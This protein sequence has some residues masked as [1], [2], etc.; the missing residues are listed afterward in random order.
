MGDS[1]V[2]NS[3][4]ERWQMARLVFWFLFILPLWV[5]RS[6]GVHSPNH[7]TILMWR[8][9]CALVGL[10]GWSIC[11]LVMYFRFP[12]P[13]KGATAPNTGPARL[14]M[15]LPGNAPVAP[16]P[17]GVQANPWDST[18]R[19]AYAAPATPQP[20]PDLSGP[21]WI[22]AYQSQRA[23]LLRA[24]LWAMSH[25]KPDRGTLFVLLG[26]PAF[27]V[28][29][30]LS[31]WLPWGWLGGLVASVFCLL[32]CWGLV[33]LIIWENIHKRF[34]RADTVRGGHAALTSDGFYDIMDTKTAFAPWSDVTSIRQHNG[35]FFIRYHNPARTAVGGNLITGAGFPD[36]ATADQFYQSALTLWKS[37]GRDLPDNFPHSS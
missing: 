18:I 6:V 30:S 31:M 36:R 2:V 14:A 37:G 12:A 34:P 7:H 11:A 32:L 1:I 8:V 16:L 33:A 4:R 23:N 25:R 27:G 5:G 24:E 19:P 15:P 3:A 22:I 20:Q 17:G 10:V 29:L 9:G 35:D 28:L 13:P 21:H 26:P